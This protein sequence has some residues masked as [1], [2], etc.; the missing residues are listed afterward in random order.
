MQPDPRTLAIVA[1]RNAWLAAIKARDAD[2][3][4]ALVTD[5]VVVV[6]GNGRC[7]VGKNA[8]EA[9][10]LAGF[11]NFLVDQ[12]VTFAETTFVGNYV[13]DIAEVTTS[14]TPVAGGQAMNVRSQA[15]TILRS[16]PDG[17]WKVARVVGLID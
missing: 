9:D 3:L 10:F 8:V 13:L 12:E 11:A 16:Q 6:H 14:L 1:V 7:V 4:T 5:D 15:V 2:A 17:S